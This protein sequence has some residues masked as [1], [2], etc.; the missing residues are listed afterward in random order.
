MF[1]PG[2]AD[3]LHRF[4]QGEPITARPPNFLGRLDRWAGSGRSWPPRSSPLTIFYSFHLVLLALGMP[5]EGGFFHWFVTGLVATWAWGRR[6]P[7]A[8]DS[9]TSPDPGHLRLG[10]PGRHHADLAARPGGRSPHRPAVRLPS[11]DCRHDPALRV[12]LVWFVTFLSVASYIGVV[13]DA[14]WRRPELAV[15]PKDWV[16]FTLSLFVL[17]LVQQLCC[18]ESAW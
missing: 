6:V 15:E 18:G 1:G 17:G 10:R 12:A 7:M 5:G 8:D 9:N 13:L 2:L 11:A 14:R 16:I 4:R 3:D